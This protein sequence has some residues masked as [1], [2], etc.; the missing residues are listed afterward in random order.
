MIDNPPP[1][2]GGG[3]DEVIERQL[4]GYRI[5]ERKPTEEVRQKQAAQKRERIRRVGDRVFH[6]LDLLFVVLYALLAGRLLL[7]LAGANQE[8]GFFRFLRALTQPFYGPF[9]D[10]VQSPKLAGATFEL[11]IAICMLAY[12]LL[13]LVLREILH[14]VFDPRQREAEQ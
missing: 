8:A 13:H 1:G 12:L 14:V 7:V 10:L 5:L 11:P 4:T 6:L 3:G 2:P 9:V